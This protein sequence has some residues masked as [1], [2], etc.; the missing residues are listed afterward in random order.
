MSA[1]SK[2]KK[3]GE[4]ILL[5]PGAAGWEIWSGPSGSE[6]EVVKRSGEL[7]AL[8]VAGVPSGDLTMAF[9][10]RDVSALPFL[11]PTTDESL[12][13][14]MADMH[15][16]R[17]GMRPLIE[18][19][20]L[21]DCFRV[22]VRGENSL[23]LPVVLAPPLEGHLP[24][25]S[26][27]AFDISARC[28]PL[29]ESGVV[30]WQELGR[31]VFAVAEQ[32]RPLHFQALAATTLGEDTGREIRLSVS[33]LQIQGLVES[34]PEYCFVWIGEE[35]PPVY[36]ED[37]DLLGNGF[38]GTATVLE[39]PSPVIPGKPSHLLPADVRAE[40]MAKRQ[41]QQMLLGVAA[42]VLVYLGLVGWAAWT[43][44]QAKKEVKTAQRSYDLIAPEV[45]GI[46]EHLRKWDE[47]RP[48]TELE[49]WPVE[50]MLN[51]SKAPARPGVAARTGRDCQ[52]SEVRRRGWNGDR[53][54]YPPAGKCR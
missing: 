36:P 7:L 35:E 17:L 4:Q 11:A 24:K 1:K 28:L 42:L 33:Q 18:A 8:E 6:L 23:L 19:G 14:D 26:P 45:A 9:P 12:Y 48:I 53:A 31:W 47:L 20:V 3:K 21:S 29:P 2:K 13:Q 43:L 25:R 16:E 22:G 38:G 5:L 50:L 15:V 30:V 32:G 51:C 44:V 46:E 37:L 27:K 52:Q 41:R 34:T 39:K 49:H 40:R 10:V 54:Q